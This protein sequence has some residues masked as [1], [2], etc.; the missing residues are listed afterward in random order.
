MLDKYGKSWLTGPELAEAIADL[1]I[2]PHREDIFLLTRHYDKDGD[3]RLLYSDFCDAFSPQDHRA[4][5][6]LGQRESFHRRM[7]IPVC[8]FFSC[9]TREI[10]RKLLKMHFTFEESNELLRKRLSKR[11]NFNIHKAFSHLDT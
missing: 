7:N 11:P 4:S 9:E 5:M 6:M 1:N 3:G 10:F 8:N 2:Y